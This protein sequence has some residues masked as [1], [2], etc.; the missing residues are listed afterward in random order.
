MKKLNGWKRL[1]IILS[2]IWVFGVA[3]HE[4]NHREASY[5][6]LIDMSSSL[7]KTMVDAH[8]ETDWLKCLDK[9]MIEDQKAAY[10]GMWTDIGIQTSVSTILLWLLA[11]LVV[12]TCRWIF[13]GFDHSGYQFRFDHSYMGTALGLVAIALSCYWHFH[14]TARL[15]AIQIGRYQLVRENDFRAYLID[16][17]TGESFQWVTVKDANGQTITEHWERTMNTD[18]DDDRTNGLAPTLKSSSVK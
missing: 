8:T 5:Q 13:S 9:K 11:Y 10:D 15:T 16:T 3:L 12:F 2:I 7:C 1:G 14:S 17:A 6:S 4:M 18:L